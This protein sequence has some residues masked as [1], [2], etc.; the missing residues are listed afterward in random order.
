MGIRV[1]FS[2][3]AKSDRFSTIITTTTTNIL[4]N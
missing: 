1:S 4:L 2:K 3:K